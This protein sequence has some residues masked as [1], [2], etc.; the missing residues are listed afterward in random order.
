MESSDGAVGNDQLLGGNGMH[1]ARGG[2]GGPENVISTSFRG[3]T[4][5]NH[6]K[7]ETYLYSAVVIMGMANV[8]IEVFTNEV[9]KSMV[10]KA[11]SDALKK[12]YEFCL[13]KNTTT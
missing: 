6:V 12:T 10:F 9:N 13:S 1:S 8:T 4:Y 7:I 11:F 3:D 5:S 2:G